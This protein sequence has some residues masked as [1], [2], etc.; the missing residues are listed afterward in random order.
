MSLSK[1][2]NLRKKWQ[3]DPLSP[4]LFAILNTFADQTCTQSIKHLSRGLNMAQDKKVGFG[5]IDVIIKYT[6]M[7]EQHEEINMTLADK[8]VDATLVKSYDTFPPFWTQETP[9]LLLVAPHHLLKFILESSL[10]IPKS[11]DGMMI[12]RT[13]KKGYETSTTIKTIS[14]HDTLCC[15]Q[16][17]N[18]IFW[19][20][21][22]LKK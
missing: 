19:I 6:Q 8:T 2:D 7:M 20:K 1:K 12:S 10:S 11:M 18:S 3:D 13:F 17:M 14:T 5:M 9:L 15:H 22:Q 4:L 16:Y 21:I